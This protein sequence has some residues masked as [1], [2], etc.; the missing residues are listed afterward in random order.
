[1]GGTVEGSCIP[2][3]IGKCSVLY[4]HKMLNDNKLHTN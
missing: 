3:V 1:L 2:T 4:N